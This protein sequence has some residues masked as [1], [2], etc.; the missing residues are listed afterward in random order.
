MRLLLKQL[1]GAL[2]QLTD[3]WSQN[4]G[5][6]IIAETT[7]GLLCSILGLRDPNKFATI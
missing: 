1:K 7:S 3:V 6:D 4:L 5:E 2:A